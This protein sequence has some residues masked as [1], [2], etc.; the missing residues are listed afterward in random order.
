MSLLTR[1]VLLLALTALE[2]LVTEAT[3]GPDCDGLNRTL[4]AEH[5]HTVSS[6]LSTVFA[7]DVGFS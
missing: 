1:V 2:A 7:Q 5:L 6:S 4:P 3:P